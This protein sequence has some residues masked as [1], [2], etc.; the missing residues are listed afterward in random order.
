MASTAST[1]STLFSR[2]NNPHL[3]PVI[4]YN[5][6]CSVASF[7]PSECESGSHQINVEIVNAREFQSITDRG[8]L[9]FLLVIDDT[10][11]RIPLR[12]DVGPTGFQLNFSKVITCKGSDSSVKLVALL[13]KKSL[14][15]G[16]EQ[17]VEYATTASISQGYAGE[18]A[19]EGYYGQPAGLVDMTVWEDG[20][21]KPELC[22]DID[23][24]LSYIMHIPRQREENPQELDEVPPN[25]LTLTCSRIR[26]CLD[27][28]LDLEWI[29]CKWK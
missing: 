20:L 21:E 2:P 24:A 13:K 18:V 8:E 15:D 12:R 29:A 14:V 3:A 7:E 19:F 9:E 1:I 4:D 22:S 16:L 28:D 6:E 17:T 5:S 11:I 23:S 10:K 25:F 26:K 27:L